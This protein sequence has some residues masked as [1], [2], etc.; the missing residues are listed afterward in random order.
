MN[1]STLDIVVFF[2]LRGYCHP[3]IA[4]REGE[5]KAR[6]TRINRANLDSRQLDVVSLARTISS[7]GAHETAPSAPPDQGVQMMLKR[8]LRAA[9]QDGVPVEGVVPPWRSP[10]AGSTSFRL[11]K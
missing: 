8:H 9:A 6:F 3:L 5:N 4:K 10:R 7:P 11:D 1:P 2:P